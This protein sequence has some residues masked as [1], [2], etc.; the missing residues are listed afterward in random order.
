MP[1]RTFKQ[2]FEGCGLRHSDEE[3]YSAEQLDELGKEL[4]QRSWWH[5][6]DAGLEGAHSDRWKEDP[7]WKDSFHNDERIQEIESILK[8]HG[9]LN[10]PIISFGKKA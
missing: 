1:G 2:F 6:L 5:D 3:N 7:R 9:K 4:Q 8:Q 10:R